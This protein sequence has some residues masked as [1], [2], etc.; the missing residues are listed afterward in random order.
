M[1]LGTL[2]ASEWVTGAYAAMRS[3]N[4]PRKKS[5]E[6]LVYLGVMCAKVR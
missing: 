4:S 1:G 6:H 2:Q 3:L 5:C